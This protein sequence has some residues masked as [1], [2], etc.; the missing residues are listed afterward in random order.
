MAS[1]RQPSDPSAVEELRQIHLEPW[2]ERG[3][4][5]FAVPSPQ[6]HG[7]VEY[8]DRTLRRIDDP[9][10]ADSESEVS[11]DLRTNIWKALARRENFNCDI[12][13]QRHPL[14]RRRLARAIER[15]IRDRRRALHISGR[16]YDGARFHGCGAVITK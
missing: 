14:V 7:A 6:A 8:F 11:V 3:G 2:R 16:R 12:R 15:D 10:F 4:Q 9:D 13:R 1:G 5:R